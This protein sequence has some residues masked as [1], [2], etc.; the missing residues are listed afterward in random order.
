M[1][2]ASAHAASVTAPTTVAMSG[3]DS[4][5]SQADRCQ[6][7]QGYS[8][9]RNHASSLDDVTPKDKTLSERDLFGGRRTVA[10]N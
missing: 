7:E 5:L 10:V 2:A 4:W 6:R 9:F 3:C 1:N 8:R